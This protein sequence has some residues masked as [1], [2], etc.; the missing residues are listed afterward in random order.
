MKERAKYGGG[1]GGQDASRYPVITVITLN[2]FNPYYPNIINY[3]F[4]Q[5]APKIQNA[6]E[7][8]R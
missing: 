6:V 7:K 2:P 3:Y 4:I 5:I 8:A 1:R